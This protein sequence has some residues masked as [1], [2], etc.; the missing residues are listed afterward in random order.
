MS[1]QQKTL[2]FDTAATREEILSVVSTKRWSSV[3]MIASKLGRRKNN[4]LY[5]LLETMTTE[6]YIERKF[7]TL[8]NGV[9]ML[10][11]RAL[12]PQE[13]QP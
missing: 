3:R 4:S 5:K 12:T 2:W 9:D 11:Y 6:G 10:L 8:P 13:E 7:R 1:E